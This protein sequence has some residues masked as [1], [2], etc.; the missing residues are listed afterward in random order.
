MLFSLGVGAILTT[1]SHRP[2]LRQSKIYK[3]LRKKIFGKSS[4]PSLKY[5]YF[6]KLLEKD[7]A[8]LDAPLSMAVSTLCSMRE[9]TNFLLFLS[10]SLSSEL[11]AR[12]LLVDSTFI[13]ERSSL[14]SRLNAHLREGFVQLVTGDVDLQHPPILT[15]AV[16]NVHFLPSGAKKETM[17]AIVD[18]E[19]LQQVIEILASDYDYVIFLQD[20]L[21]GDTRYIHIS[22]QVKFNLLLVEEYGTLMSDI[23]ECQNLYLN[24]NI[25]DFRLV[26]TA[27]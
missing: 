16:K 5:R 14:T 2:V 23:D 8:D 4:F 22:K 13:Y 1:N 19:R 18:H 6:C 15:T 25:K 26:M 27:T 10:Y 24:N 11:N 7:L 17:S 9:A 20:D 21:R 3:Y 12:V